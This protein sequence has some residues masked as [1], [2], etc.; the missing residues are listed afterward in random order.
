MNKLR[1][2]LKSII[3][4]FYVLYWML[5]YDEG[6]SPKTPIK[7]VFGEVGASL[8][9]ADFGNKGEVGAYGERKTEQI[10]NAYGD[11][12]SIIHDVIVPGLDAN[13]DHVIVSGSKVLII[14]TKAWGSGLYHQDSAEKQVHRG[15]R[16]LDHAN[17]ASL[18]NMENMM[19]TVL[20]RR[21][22]R[23]WGL[24]VKSVLAVWPSPNAT[25]TTLDAS[26]RHRGI[27]ILPAYKLDALMK[28]HIGFNKG[29]ELKL[30]E[31]LRG[32]R[33]IPMEQWMI[34][35]EKNMPPSPAEVVYQMALEERAERVRAK[36]EREV[37]AKKKA[38]REAARRKEM[39]QR[40]AVVKDQQRRQEA[41]L[42]AIRER[43]KLER[44]NGTWPQ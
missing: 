25:G 38:D 22:G 16:P 31:A 32:M 33:Y 21:R 24:R 29:G 15:N 19:R 30:V 14:D 1:Q 41:A 27:P 13:L 44:E 9:G 3:D 4:Y 43:E 2:K 36:D 7:G 17:K 20:G 40:N 42:Q 5:R 6:R 23:V 11:R 37:E 12:C 18:Q 28:R 34:D 10:L 8:D 26:L 35:A 39:A